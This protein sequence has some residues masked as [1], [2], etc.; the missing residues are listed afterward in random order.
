MLSYPCKI[1]LDQLEDSA[2][3]ILPVVSAGRETGGAGTVGGE[4][5][6]GQSADYPEITSFR[7]VKFI[8]S[9]NT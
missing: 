8:V 3:G 2:P 7:P 6:R 5:A 1:V 9:N 4:N